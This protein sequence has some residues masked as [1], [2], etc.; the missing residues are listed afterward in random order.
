PTKAF[1]KLKPKDFLDFHKLNSI[2]NLDKD[3]EFLKSLNIDKNKEIE[4]GKWEEIFSFIQ[5][6]S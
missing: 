2:L 5:K 3:L 1:E 6:K 4:Q